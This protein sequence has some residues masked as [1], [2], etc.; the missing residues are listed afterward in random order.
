[1]T[2]SGL[3]NEI[4]SLKPVKTALVG[5]GH[6]GTYHAEKLFKNSEAALVAVCDPSKEK[7]QKLAEKYSCEA[8]SDFKQIT[9]KVSAVVISTPTPFHF[10][11][12]KFFLEKGKHLLIEKPI[13]Q[14][15][16]EAEKL[17]EL[18]K[19]QN[20]ILQVGHV[21]RFNPAYVKFKEL[22]EAQR[23]RKDCSKVK[24]KEG[25]KGDKIETLQ[26]SKLSTNLPQTKRGQ[27]KTEDSVGEI[28]FIKARRLA[29]FQPRN[30]DVNV[31]LDLMVHDIDLVLDLAKSPL[32]FISALGTSVVTSHIDFAH[33]YLQFESGLTAS[34]TASRVFEKSVREWEV[35][36]KEGSFFHINF[37]TFQVSQFEMENFLGKENKSILLKDKNKSTKR[38][39]ENKNSRSWTLK[40]KDALF[41]QDKA[42]INSV[43]DSKKPIVGGSEAFKVMEVVEQ[44][45][46]QIL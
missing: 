21:E 13:T 1:M 36:Q 18:A 42:F 34:L 25:L 45:H 9:E 30:T 5:A 43:L 22:L 19:N 15:A 12:A 6:L 2:F 17:S 29:P 33:A 14:T 23:V 10:E 20:L 32:K 11:V 28:L 35:F 39:G 41:E 26:K 38:Q 37:N 24:D 31:V 40:K 27:L 16:R 3:N 4:K 46:K 7:A 8:F 44:I